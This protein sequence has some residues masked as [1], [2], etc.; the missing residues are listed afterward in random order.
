MCS[1]YKK[2][3]T[4]Q[5]QTPN[6]KICHITFIL[7]CRDLIHQKMEGLPLTAVI[8]KAHHQTVEAPCCLSAF[9]NPITFRLHLKHNIFNRNGLHS[10]ITS[11]NNLTDRTTFL[12][13]VF[14]KI[15]TTYVNYR[16]KRGVVGYLWKRCRTTLCTLSLAVYWVGLLL[17]C[18]FSLNLNGW[19]RDSSWPTLSM[20]QPSDATSV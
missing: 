14:T 7:T 13:K 19:S 5:K 18:H 16:S 12:G 17:L 15:L 11:Y 9:N 2:K 4:K 3:N 1:N 6:T 8:T 20:R 10:P